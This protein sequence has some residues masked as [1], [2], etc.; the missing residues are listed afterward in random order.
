VNTTQ[1]WNEDNECEPLIQS[2]WEGVEVADSTLI[3]IQ[4]K[5]EECKA[6]LSAWSSQ[7]FGN[8][9]QKVQSLTRRL[10]NL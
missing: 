1:P 7:K 10:E 2:I 4:K 5:L 8:V 3:G 6:T 9:A